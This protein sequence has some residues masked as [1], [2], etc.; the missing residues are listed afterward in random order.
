[1][2]RKYG[3]EDGSQ[4]SGPFITSS[5]TFAVTTSSHGRV[6]GSTLALLFFAS[7]A[8]CLRAFKYLWEPGN[9]ENSHLRGNVWPMVVWKVGD[10]SS[11]STSWNCREAPEAHKSNHLNHTALDQISFFPF[12]C[13][14]KMSLGPPSQNKLS[15]GKPLPEALPPETDFIDWNAGD[16]KRGE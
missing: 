15:P 13:S 2:K 11:D 1:M 6:P 12:Y 7:P 10:S 9:P 4:A 5:A 14:N 16:W 8:F 3:V